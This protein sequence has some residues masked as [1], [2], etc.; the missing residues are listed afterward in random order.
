MAAYPNAAV[1][2]LERADAY[3]VLGKFAEAA[4]DV[5]S[6]D[7]VVSDK[8]ILD[9]NNLA[10]RLTTGRPEV[11]NPTRALELVNKIGAAQRGNYLNTIGVVQY[12][13]ELY[14][15]AIKTLVESLATG[16]GTADAY[17]LYFLAMAYGK[18]GDLLKAQASY[19]SASLWMLKQTRLPA[20]AAEELRR[21]RQE[22]EE[23]LRKAEGKK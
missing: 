14:P 23:V 1:F 19:L 22:A 18:V 9:L 20:H 3:E 10:W 21:F 11:R 17:D 5:R 4:A 8:S 13:N 7:K 12:R 15:Q 6:A 16:K 2:Y